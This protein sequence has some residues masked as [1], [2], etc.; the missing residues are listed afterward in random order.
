MVENRRSTVRP[1]AHI[2]C[3]LQGER[4]ETFRASI[5]DVTSRGARVRTT[6]QLATG[7][8]VTMAI[9]SSDS[10]F[11]AQVRWQKGNEIGLQFLPPAVDGDAVDENAFSFKLQVAE[12]RRKVEGLVSHPADRKRA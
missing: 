1:R 10:R 3:E 8:V 2:D 6:A 5:K 12:L 11:R 7:A 4:G 9:F